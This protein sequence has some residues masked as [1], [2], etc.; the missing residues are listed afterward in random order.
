MPHT[1]PLVDMKLTEGEA[2]EQ[3]EPPVGDKP[4][5]PFGL[6][7]HLSEESIQKLG[8]KELPKVG[9]KKILLARVVCERV[10][11]RETIDGGV[12]RS[13]S[14]QITHMNLATPG[15]EKGSNAD[16]AKALYG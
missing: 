13:I 15:K 10:E 11:E 8:L 6:E 2:K 12:D 16:T 1:E 7:V 5:F 14:L 9:Q 4:K 3:M